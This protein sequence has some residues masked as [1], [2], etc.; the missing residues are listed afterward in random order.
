MVKSSYQELYTE[1][2]TARPTLDGIHFRQLSSEAN[3][4]LS[5]PFCMDEIK[6][7]VWSCDGDKCPRPYG[8]NFT[9]FKHFW[10]EIKGELC[11]VVDEFFENA[12]LPKGFCSSFITLIPKRD[13]PQGMSD[14][15]PISLI[16]SLHK[17]LAKLLAAR[18]KR[19]LSP[20]ISPCQSV[21][22]A[23]R[24]ILDGVLAVSEVVDLAKKKKE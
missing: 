10:E 22:L 2:F 13:N 9:F 23:S 3:E 8:F 18:L 21:F 1:K 24:K 20:L 16:G 11:D 6:D 4:V 15:R 19:V 12:A 5:V 7:A 14:Y 17:L